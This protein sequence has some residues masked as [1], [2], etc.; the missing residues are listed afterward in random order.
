MV[1]QL[2]IVLTGGKTDSTDAVSE[3][4]LSA[5]ERQALATLARN[6]LTIA[7]MEHMLETGK[8]LRN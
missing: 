6:P 4:D 8:P 7:R 2:G 1:D 3:D 5:L